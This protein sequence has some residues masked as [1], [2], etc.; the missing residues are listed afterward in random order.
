MKPDLKYLKAEF[1]LTDDLG[2]S[3]GNAMQ[4]WFTIADEIYFNRDKLCVP[5]EWQFKPSPLGPSNDPDDYVTNVV[6]NTP[7]ETL[8]GFGNLVHRYASLLKSKR[9]DY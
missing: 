3:W 4:W 5:D 2:D 1:R 9:M 7:D 6:K 8:M